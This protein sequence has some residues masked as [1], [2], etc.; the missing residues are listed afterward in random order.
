[1]WQ[2]VM[3]AAASLPHLC[4]VDPSACNVLSWP[5]SEETEDDEVVAKRRRLAKAAYEAWEA[6]EAALEEWETWENARSG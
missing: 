2:H 4:L 5:V 1:M 6:A 3:V